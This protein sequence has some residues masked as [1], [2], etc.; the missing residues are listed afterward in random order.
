MG[1]SQPAR[2]LQQHFQHS[3]KLLLL[4]QITLL[5]DSIFPSGGNESLVGGVVT[6]GM[7]EAS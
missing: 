3:P 2:D 6:T 4:S 7:L 1:C 5:G